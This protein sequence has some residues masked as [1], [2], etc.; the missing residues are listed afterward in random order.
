MSYY[1]RRRTVS[2]H[3]LIAA[4]TAT[5]LV[6]SPLLAVLLAPGAGVAL[7]GTNPPP[8]SIVVD[9]LMPFEITG[10]GGALLF[11]GTL[12]NRVSRTAAG[13]LIFH[14]QIR[15]TQGGLNGIVRQI[16]TL[17]FGGLPLDVDF[18]P[19]S[20]GNAQPTRAQRSGGDG[21]LVSFIYGN[22][23]FAGQTSKFCWIA[24]D[25]QHA[26]RTG[27]T[28]I[29]LSTGESVTLQTW[30]PVDDETPPIAVI[31]SPGPFGCACNP[32]TVT[33]TAN[34][35]EGF[36]S[37]TLEWTAN[38]ADPWTLIST[39][40]SP[41]INGTLGVWNTTAVSQGYKF[42]RLRATNDA[43]MESQ[44]TTAVWVDKQFDTFSTGSPANGG[45]YG[46]TQC[47][48]GTIWDHCFDQYTVEFRSGTS[49]TFMP[50]NPAMPVYT[51]TV[52]NGTLATWDTTTVPDGAYQIRV[53]ARDICGHA[54]A[55]T[56][57]IVVDNTPPVVEISSPL[58]CTWHCGTVQI[59]GTVTDTNL[60]NWV[61]QYVGGDT[62]N[63]VTIASGTGPVVNG[64]LAEW[65]T[66]SLERCAY[67]LRLL[68]T[69]SATLNCGPFKHQSEYITTVNIGAYANC[70]GSTIPP[71]LNVDDFTCFINQFASGGACP[72]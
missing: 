49:G 3:H 58:A 45:I 44:F 33:G 22:G 2:P 55:V 19:G 11:R 28:T 64:L 61:L 70:D 17:D 46:G 53:S 71:I 1:V 34:D 25:Q 27:Y 37:Y 51:S 7:P 38:P 24:T 41:V 50:V 4:C 32:T 60:Q 6:G 14:Y 42:L 67:A 10:G 65:N 13:D 29:V 54:E 72:Q 56:R 62:H 69:D 9:E 68:A 66:S 36:G 57:N 23:F 21:N 59:T 18:A 12:Q 20:L 39:S 31:T 52:I 43:A 26:A 8:S 15:D 40:T 30:M 5:M 48:S 35:P 63:W 16:D 47:T